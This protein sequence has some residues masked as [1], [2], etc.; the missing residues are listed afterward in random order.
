M[1]ELITIAGVAIT[2]PGILNAAATVLKAAYDIYGKVT[3]RK[4]QLNILLERCRDLIQK[5]AEMLEKERQLSDTLSEGI[6]SITSACE[7]VKNVCQILSQK[8]FLWCVMNTDKIDVKL[9]KADVDI[10]DAFT[11]FGIIAQ[12]DRVKF[13]NELVHARE[14]DQAV[15]TT[16]LKQ[17]SDNDQHIIKAI[18]DQDGVHRRMEELLV[19]IFKHVQTLPKQNLSRPEDLF[20]KNAATALQRVSQP[21]RD[22]L[23]EWMLSS[24]EVE[25][26]ETASIGQG[27]FGV[28]HGGEWNGALVA[29]KRMH[30]DDARVVSTSNLK[31]I[32]KEVKIWTK[33]RHPNILPLY[34]ACLEASIPFLVMQHC[35]FGNICHYLRTNSDRANRVGLSGDVVSALLYLHH[36][37]IVHADL[38]GGNVLVGDNHRA[39]LTD[40]GLS[41]ILDDIRSQS[42]I[43]SQAGPRGTLRWM[44]PECLDGERPDKASDVY[45]LGITIW[46]IFSEEVPFAKYVDRVLTRVVVDQ[47]KRPARPE[48]LTDDGIWDII[49]RCWGPDPTSRPSVDAVHRIFKGERAVLSP[50]PVLQHSSLFETTTQA[51]VDT[52]PKVRN[53]GSSISSTEQLPTV[54]TRTGL[55]PPKWIRGNPPSYIDSVTLAHIPDH[56]GYGYRVAKGD[57]DL[58]IRP[59]YAP[60]PDGSQR[61]N[62]LEYNQGYGI[63]DHIPIKV[64][65]IDPKDS[66]EMMVA[67]HI[68]SRQ[69]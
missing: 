58:G 15:L 51:P 21:R 35:Q 66:S 39:L 14:Q 19:A 41:L 16:Q 9:A 43:S 1:A 68:P 52:A 20:L 67:E 13:Q 48:R 26:D 53:N 62:L 27:S 5:V 38:K 3:I 64:F 17:L 50:A 63:A 6:Q 8:G 61:V 34:G 40:F 42:A 28:I 47:K 24:L 55:T 57:T 59:G 25:F 18:Q 69:R 44:A 10:S 22:F 45:S 31:I 37:D 65:A 49:Q 11:M 60:E 23:E 56:E 29:I 54:W 33:L 12:I 2:I 46:E 4:E 36:N 32:R 30:R 7:A